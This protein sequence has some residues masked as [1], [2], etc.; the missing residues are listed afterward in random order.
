[1]HHRLSVLLES[2]TDFQT[3][4]HGRNSTE[5]T[6]GLAWRA[7]EYL[8]LEAGGTVESDGTWKILFAWEWNFAGE[9]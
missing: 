5:G 1:L 9:D 7:N 2:V 4:R 8:T 3:G 6:V